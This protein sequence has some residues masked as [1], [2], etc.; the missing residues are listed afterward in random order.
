[1]KS[2]VYIWY[3]LA[4]SLFLWQ[5]DLEKVEPEILTAAFSV[6]ND[7]C[8][9]P[10]SVS[11]TNE[12]KF[13]DAY[14]WDFG[15]GMT[16]EQEA[17][18]HAYA[19]AGAYE[20]S[21]KAISTRDSLYKEVSHTVT[22]LE[23]I[24]PK[25]AFSIENDGCYAPCEVK[26][27]NESEHATSYKWDFGDGTVSDLESP[28]H[29]Y[30]VAGG[31]AVSLTAERDTFSDEAQ[32]YITI[33]EPIRF[34]KGIGGT[35]AELGHDLLEIAGGGYVLVGSST[36]SSSGT[37]DIYIV[38]TD[39]YGTVIHENFIDLNQSQDVG[40]AIVE[41]STGYAVA[42]A[43]SKNGYTDGFLIFIDNDGNLFTNKTQLFEGPDTEVSED[44]LYDLV[45]LAN[46]QFAMVGRTTIGAISNG[47]LVVTDENGSV[48]AN[49]RF[50]NIGSLNSI[51]QAKDSRLVMAGDNSILFTDISGNNLITET[52]PYSSLK[53][54]IQTVDDGLALTGLA[55]HL[56]GGSVCTL[57][58][59]DRNGKNVSEYQLGSRHTEAYSLVQTENG[60]FG[61]AG[62]GDHPDA[63]SGLLIRSDQNGTLLWEKGFAI[64][65][66]YEEIRAVIVTKD[67]GFAMVGYAGGPDTQLSFFKT[68]A[69]GNTN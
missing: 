51:I 54:I 13:A 19:Q 20:V 63:K 30:T 58:K 27:I 40:Y 29:T 59:A 18:T 52:L 1:M 49:K 15:D 35:G 9:M 33:L 39:E 67:N 25:A 34:E 43:T 61:L 23:P 45:P 38:I 28:T 7:S 37:Q 24:P 69:D 50:T 55:D 48:S 22:I 68:D 16:S 36:S 47:Y 11:F 62:W 14:E 32:K 42:G 46:G 8:T 31:Y 65:G 64:Q 60:D 2:P 44:I 53:S 56:S 10:C 66:F 4:A 3:I 5:C 26:F 12:S 57:I 17:P 6:E 41:T 21:L